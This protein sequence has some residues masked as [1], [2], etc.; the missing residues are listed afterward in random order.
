MISFAPA[1]TAASASSL[2][3]EII[4]VF[5]KRCVVK[6][7]D[8]KA[9][10]KAERWQEISKSAAKQAGRGIIPQVSDPPPFPPYLFFATIDDH[11]PWRFTSR[12]SSPASFTELEAVFPPVLY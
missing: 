3:N 11:S 6:L 5:M 1:Q 12:T 4:P 9:K 8:K 10:K 7:D 2:S